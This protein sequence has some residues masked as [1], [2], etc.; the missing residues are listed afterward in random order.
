MKKLALNVFALTVLLILIVAALDIF[1][2]YQPSATVRGDAPVYAVQKITIQAPSDK[3]W[4]VLSQIDHWEEWQTDISHPKLSGPLQAGSNFSW[5]T[6]GARIQSTLHTVVP[7][8]ELG[9][10]GKSF[11]RFAIHN[12]ILRQVGDS[13]EVT[14]EESMEG[15]LVQLLSG[16]FQNKLDAAMDNSLQALKQQA[17]QQ[18]GQQ[19]KKQ[20][21]NAPAG[22]N[23]S[24]AAAGHASASAML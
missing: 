18:T 15:W 23:A 11:G 20:A 10:Y 19:T 14:V 5:K 1:S 2:S 17:E 16:R 22:Q 8:A 13:T 4:R 7:N 3:V 9:W 6:N 12:W 21:G 24:H